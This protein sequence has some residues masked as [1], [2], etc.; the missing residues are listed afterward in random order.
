MLE[1]QKVSLI[2]AAASD[3]NAADILAQIVKGDPT[4][5]EQVETLGT[6]LKSIVAREAARNGEELQAYVPPDAYIGVRLA[7][8]QDYETMMTAMP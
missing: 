4:S 8:E 1:Q 7:A 6:I 3:E 5:P 2:A